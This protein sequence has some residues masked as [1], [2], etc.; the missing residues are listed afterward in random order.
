MADRRRGLL[1]LWLAYLLFILYGTTL[2]F[3]MDW[4][5]ARRKWQQVA[6]PPLVPNDLSLPD[7]LS[8]ILLFVP[9]G[10]LLGSYWNFSRSSLMGATSTVALTVAAGAGFSALLELWQL[11]L[12]SRT[13]S[14]VDVMANS[15]GALFGALLAAAL[16]KLAHAIGEPRWRFFLANYPLTVLLLALMPTQ[17]AGV[18]LPFDISI[19]ISD[20]KESLK[21]ANVQPFGSLTLLGNPSGPFSLA[22]FLERLLR[23]AL[24]G[25][26]FGICV[27]WE[28]KAR[29][30]QALGLWGAWAS[31]MIAA[32]VLQLVVR[33]RTFDINDLL[34]GLLGFL[35]GNAAFW[36]W[37]ASRPNASTTPLALP[38]ALRL[39]LVPYLALL[40]VAELSPFD[41]S[42]APAAIAAKWKH[43]EF[44]PFTA[45]YSKTSIWSLEDLLETVMLALPAGLWVGWRHRARSPA[46]TTAWA[47][48]TGLAIGGILEVG[49]LLT[50]SRY[51]GIT[52][53][54]SFGIGSAA[55]SGCIVAWRHAVFRW[56][57]EAGQ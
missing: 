3:D 45:Y 38:A 53:V 25:W 14:L 7:I 31:L 36:A 9:F 40:V 19:D 17:F 10:L 49:Q 32:E 43:F 5:Q 51:P 8:N 29:R 22:Q 48:L 24:C 42:F 28:W 27:R 23:F 4:R 2:P 47:L 54:L 21:R 44:L 1:W 35:L 52:D 30:L 26:L 57:A 37:M 6:S 39:M 16:A 11:F 12:P 20:L 18:L 41:F 55:G 46:E 56:K 33:S 50:K 15:A 13:T 34:S